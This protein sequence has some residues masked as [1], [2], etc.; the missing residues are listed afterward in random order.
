MRQE[1]VALVDAVLFEIGNTKCIQD[2]DV[3]HGADELK[4]DIFRLSRFSL[5]L[6]VRHGDESTDGG[7]T[8]LRITPGSQGV[9]IH[10]LFPLAEY[11]DTDDNHR[12]LYDV[13]TTGINH[14]KMQKEAEARVQA[15]ARA[16]G[17]RLAS[18]FGRGRKRSI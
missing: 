3:A 2:L 14:I 13:F 1:N 16:R 4:A 6:G 8:E 9:K 12:L 18:L 15:E 17:S 10:Q 5:Y 11:S 7:E